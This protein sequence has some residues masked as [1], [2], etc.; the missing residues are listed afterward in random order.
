MSRLRQLYESMIL[1]HHRNP[2]NYRSIPECSHSSHGKNPLC[3][4]DFFVFLT[5]KNDTIEDI[6]FFGDGCAISKSSGSLMTEFL[7]GKTV[8]HAI[9]TKD[10]FIKLVTTDMDESEKKMLGKLTVFEGVKAYPVRVK[11]A[12]LVWRALEDALENH[13]GCVSTE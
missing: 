9:D 6:S 3:G 11:C 7:K 2:R 8:Q 4:D 12:A 10:A 1:E 5:I 13:T